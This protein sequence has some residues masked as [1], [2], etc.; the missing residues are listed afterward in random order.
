MVGKLRF[1]VPLALVAA[2]ALAG[3]LLVPMLPEPSVASSSDQNMTMHCPQCQ[4]ASDCNSGCS[5]LASPAVVSPSHALQTRLYTPPAMVHDSLGLMLP[6][7]P[8]RS[9]HI[10]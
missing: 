10:Y 1:R 8:P 6:K 5:L 7:P 9:P 4:W 2:L 3:A